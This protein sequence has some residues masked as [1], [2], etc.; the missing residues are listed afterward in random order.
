M[1]AQELV[2]GIRWELL[3][4]LGSQPR[5]GAELARLLGTTPANISQHLKLLELAGLV[6]R[7][8]ANG[9][10]MHYSIVGD[11][12]LLTVLSKNA[13]RSVIPL[14]GLAALELRLLTQAWPDGKL[15][16]RF[17]IEYEELVE[18]FLGFGILPPDDRGNCQLFVLAS[19]VKH[20][21]KEYAHL[22]VGEKRIIIWSHTPEEVLGGLAHHEHYFVDM[23]AKLTPLHDPQERLRQLKERVT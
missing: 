7:E 2:T 9:K 10:S 17:I 1:D 11:T 16:R 8:R 12:A 3:K 18:T 15:L 14:S 4:T 20:L 23:L 19:E 21:R 6:Q 13:F 22:M 5:T